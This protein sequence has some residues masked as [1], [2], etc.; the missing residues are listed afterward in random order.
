MLC[1]VNLYIMQYNWKS[2]NSGKDLIYINRLKLAEK[3]GIDIN[4]CKSNM[5]HYLM[6]AE[7]SFLIS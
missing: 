4:K 7:L 3:I 6:A 1:A 2:K 5:Y